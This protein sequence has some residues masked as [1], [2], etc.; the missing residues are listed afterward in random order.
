L[1]IFRERLG[2]TIPA[3]LL[4]GQ[5]AVGRTNEEVMKNA[6]MDWTVEK[7]RVLH[8]DTGQPLPARYSINFRSDTNEPIGAVGKN[9]TNLQ[10]KEM[11]DVADGLVGAGQA[12][13]ER[14]GQTNGGARIFAQLALPEHITIGDNDVSEAKI[15][16]S[17]SYDGSNAFRVLPTLN[18]LFCQNQTSAVLSNMRDMGI[19]PS[20]L[21]IRHSSRMHDKIKGLNRAL[22][23]TNTLNQRWAE[24]ANG[25]LEA[26]MDMDDRIQFYISTGILGNTDKKRTEKDKTNIHGLSTQGNRRL[27][28]LLELETAPTNTTGGMTDTAWAAYNTLTEYV[29][30]HSILKADGTVKQTTAENTVF[31][32]GSRVKTNAWARLVDAHL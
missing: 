10:P 24:Q 32:A 1:Y 23:L 15:Y 13:W 16:L 29:D 3:H 4:M 12:E 6:G 20:D 5:E 7:R 25:L 8:P 27:D 9:Y 18:R 26:Q 2:K 19:R 11:F 22:K 30:H 28:E 14:V 17:N 31:G 21:V